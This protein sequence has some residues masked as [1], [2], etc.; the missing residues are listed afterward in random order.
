MTYF[1]NIETSIKDSANLDAF[2]R[3]R[4]S[5]PTNVFDAQMTYDLKPTLYEQIVTGAGAAIAHD[6]TN[7]MA[8]MT[9]AATTVGGKAYMQTYEYFSYQ[10][11]KSQLIAV[12]FNMIE[13]VAN[14]LKFAGYS[15]GVNGIEFQNT[16]TANQIVI[17]SGTTLGA[18]TILQSAWNLDKLDG[19]G[20]S[21]I[22]LDITKAQILIIDFQALYVGRVRVGFDIGGNI[23]YVHEFSHANSVVYPYIQSANLPIRCGMVATG[24][25]TTTMKFICAAVASEGGQDNTS[26]FNF[27]QTRG[28]SAGNATE[29]HLFSLRAKPTF[30]SITNRSRIIIEDFQ[31]SVT[32]ANPVWWK[33]VI[34]QALTTPSWTDVNAT[35]SATQYDQTGTLS[36]SPAI[37]IRQGYVPATVQVKDSVTNL[38]TSRYP[39]ALDSTGTNRNLGQIGILVQGIGGVSQCY[40]ALNWREIQ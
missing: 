29:T 13:Q 3:L 24:T 38:V 28:V 35:Y 1:K 31:I 26:S 8:G 27:S 15:D 37:V 18:Q 10:P 11:M 7:R 2:S 5:N 6:A 23:I 17:Y 4:I 40:G 30:N 34:G 22:T 21:G 16:G 9:F 39:L 20:S 14:A 19:T 33:L 36:G 32:G 12:T 25:T